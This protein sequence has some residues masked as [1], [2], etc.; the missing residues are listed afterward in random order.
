M[1]TRTSVRVIDSIKKGATSV[2]LATVLGAL[3]GFAYAAD[4]P[5]KTPPKAPPPPPFFF[6]NENSISY[7]YQFHA[8]NPLAGNSP[9]NVLTFTH[10][11]V[12]EYGTNFFNVDYLRATNGSAPFPAVNP[13]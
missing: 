5:V 13:G 12:W 7:S 1:R 2:A 8:N 11:D 10:F 6:V 9:K 3:G 4:M